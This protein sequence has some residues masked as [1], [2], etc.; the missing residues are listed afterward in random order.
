MIIMR[1]L[2]ILLMMFIYYSSP[3]FGQEG[4]AFTLAQVNVVVPDRSPAALEQGLQQAFEKQM[5]ILSGD[6]RVILSPRVQEAAR[7]AK[8]WVETY[9]YVE[10]PGANE[11]AAPVLMLQVTFDDEAL[12]RFLNQNENLQKG[13]GLKDNTSLSD[14]QSLSIVVTDIQDMTD[15]LNAVRA[16]RSV[17]GVEKVEMKDLKSNHALITVTYSGNATYF[18]N[19]M[20]N[21]HRFHTTEN[22]LEYKWV[23]RG[24][25]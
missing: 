13:L 14:S 20:S 16:L 11:A 1:T 5:V 8:Q 19:V 7:N 21:D 17:H 24:P 22:P 3:S 2:I 18:T 25:S 4:A 10:H 12:K 23:G 6:P 9:N 15:L